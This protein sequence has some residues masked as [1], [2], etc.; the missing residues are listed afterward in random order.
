[1]TILAVGEVGGDNPFNKVAAVSSDRS[2]KNR[3]NLP[4]S[5][6]V[7]PKLRRE[8][9]KQIVLRSLQ[10]TLAA[11]DVDGLAGDET[12]GNRAEI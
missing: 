10:H 3:V 9:D 6:T 4:I 7:S 2:A 11:I 12:R 1:M 5:P 8:I